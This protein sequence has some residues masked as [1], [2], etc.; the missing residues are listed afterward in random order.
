MHTVILLFNSYKIF[1]RFRRITRALHSR[2]HLCYHTHMLFHGKRARDGWGMHHD[3]RS[4]CTRHHGGARTRGAGVRRS[5]DWRGED[6][7]PRGDE[8]PRSSRQRCRSHER[9]LG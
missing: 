7:Q 8:A 3:D 1:S 2:T 4:P 5:R 9:K 6:L